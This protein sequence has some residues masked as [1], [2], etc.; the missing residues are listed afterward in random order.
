MKRSPREV[1][2]PAAALARLRGA[3]RD[4]VGDLPTVHALHA[5]GFDAGGPL[6]E[7]FVRGLD[8]GLDTV[9]QSEF[10]ERVSRFFQ[11]RGWGELRH[12]Q[13]HPAV[14]FLHSPDWAEATDGGADQP[15]CAFGTG[16]LSQ[17]LTRVAG[18]PVAVLETACRSAGAERCTFAFGS[19]EAIHLFY[20]HLVDGLSVGEALDRL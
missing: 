18:G 20:G 9:P 15:S 11:D 7:A 16:L 14:G 1:A 2:V 6:F 12:E 19:E 3:L 17:F 4:E 8:G 10:W 5:A 13:P